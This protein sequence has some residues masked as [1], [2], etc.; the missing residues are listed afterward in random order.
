[1][2]KGAT[3]G[4]LYLNC[5]LLAREYSSKHLSLVICVLGGLI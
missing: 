1:M 2:L 4:C 5:L 3:A